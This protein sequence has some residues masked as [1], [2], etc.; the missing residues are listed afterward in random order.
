[1]RIVIDLQG[2]QSESR[3]RG[4]GRY[5]L[6]FT[7]ALAK[8][9]SLKH[10][11]VIALNSSFAESIPSI[12]KEFDGILPDEAFKIFDIAT[13]VSADNPK[14]A[15]RAEASERIREAWISSLAPDVLHIS[16]LFEGFGDDALSSIAALDPSIFTSVT[17]YDLIPLLKKE[18]YL[19][20]RAV[21]D[22]Y[23][24]KLE[25]LKKA[26]M[27]LAISE[28]S[29][30]E[31]IEA[32]GIKE[33]KICNVSAAIDPFFTPTFVSPEQSR[34]LRLKFGIK[35]EFL[36]YAPGGFDERKN[37]EHLV[38]AYSMLEPTLRQEYQLVIVGRGPQSH[39][40]AITSL[41]K[42][43]G[44]GANVILTGY[45]SDDELRMFYSSCAL[46]VFASVHEGFG[47]PLLE[48]FGCGAAGIGSNATSIPEV[49]ELEEALFDPLNP[50]SIAQ[51]IREGLTD[52][53]FRSRLKSHALSRAKNFTWELCAKKALEFFEEKIKELP[54]KSKE[55]GLKRPKMAYISPLSPTESGISTYSSRLLTALA[56]HY[57]IEVVV[58]EG[59]TDEPFVSQNLP[60]KT[61]QEFLEGSYDRA[62]FHIGNSHYHGYMFELL[63]KSSGVCVLHDFF[64]SGSFAHLERAGDKG[65]FSLKLYESHGYKGVVDLLEGG[66][67]Y[68]KTVYPLN[69]EV[70][71]NSIGVLT[72][73][74]YSKNMAKEFYG[75]GDDRV[76]KV[77]FVDML[78]N[79]K[80]KAEARKKLGFKE[81]ALVVCSFGM[82]HPTKLN[83]KLLEAWLMA[84]AAYAPNSYLVFVGKQFSG[85][86][87]RELARR[88]L[89]SGLSD[90]I[91]ITDY[92]DEERYG[93]YLASADITVQLRS[94]SRGESSGA[95]FDSISAAKAM[96]INA[97]A[98]FA[99]T[100][101][102]ICVKISDEFEIPELS[103]AIDRLAANERLRESLGAKCKE[104]IK[105]FS[106]Q[107]S[108]SRYKELIEGF[109]S[110]SSVAFFDKAVNAV[111][112]V[113]AK[114]E[115]TEEDF[116]KCAKAIFYN[117]EK[118]CQKQL[119]VDVS[120]IVLGDLKT[121]I[122]RV[123][124]SITLELIKNP[125]KGYRVEPV[126]DVGGHYKYAREY[127]LGLIGF[128]NERIKDDIVAVNGG[129]VFFGLDFFS[130]G[131]V[132]NEKLFFE[133]K[134]RG[135]FIS[136]VVYDLLP[137]FYPQF[138]MPRADEIH[139][140]WLN[141][142]KKHTDSFLCI[143]KAV[144]GELEE[145][146]KNG[147][148]PHDNKPI[149]DWFHLGADVENSA[150][151]MGLPEDFEATIAKIKSA[152]S[153]AMVGT[154]EPRKGH[155]Q[156]LSAFERLWSEGIDANLVIVG[157]RGWLVDEVAKK[158]ESHPKLG[159]RLFW[160]QG[161]SDEYLEMVYESSSALLAASEGEGYGLP[162]I[163]AAKRG[164]AIVARDIAVFREVAKDGAFYFAN[165]L[166]A[167]ALSKAIKE[168]LELYAKGSQPL[169][170]SIE[171]LTWRESAEMIKN[172]LRLA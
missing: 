32:L 112:D 76:Q 89:E 22:W 132:R 69:F 54:K 123:V 53:E 80:D 44:V 110:K 26:D 3:Y 4:I 58:E 166:G 56:D 17:L 75:L 136:F 145:W 113:C 107:A 52:D 134:A 99:E 36:L 150:P 29:K 25:Y 46:F 55:E 7:K 67:E 12:K 160:L 94:K 121:G 77:P 61:P 87:G 144:A 96:I 20:N 6:F 41:A 95:L 38:T 63:K 120:A 64:I 130:S 8:E 104:Y 148:A 128:K 159:E 114:G 165:D 117:K 43:K 115:A 108:A 146:L 137:I 39:F 65:L 51:K 33:D 34:A 140:K 2:A 86:Y 157:K 109:Y 79:K 84:D 16:S 78:A 40:D 127:S 24:K 168:W 10:E 161:I 116:S 141:S 5:S 47:L 14:N 164:L 35:K 1:M 135:V 163:E 119:L 70:F 124:R 156:A 105:N 11:V 171:V 147:S 30:Q 50:A 138:F 151:S 103:V 142:I 125:P 101:D 23:Y 74:E 85:D 31:A 18:I 73:S 111:A 15:L 162:I 59:F 68:A 49:V 152:P 133:W 21:S 13:P 170:T 139:K 37:F 81:D 169:S 83:A 98:T 45:V 154:V 57:D 42:K 90:R 48:A 66:L 82:I 131:T 122:Q 92:V 19:Q 100:P 88:I 27:L 71:E 97:H 102:D 60:V 28:S 143:S 153:F 118:V 149:V 9:A 93:D 72:H 172:R 126:Y 129:D 158:L 62:L 106:P 155:A 167:E 91:V